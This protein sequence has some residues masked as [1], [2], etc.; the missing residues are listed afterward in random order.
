[1]YVERSNEADA[2]AYSFNETMDLRGK[3]ELRMGERRERERERE[4]EEREL[5]RI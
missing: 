5:L 2:C 1:M 4:R 3:E